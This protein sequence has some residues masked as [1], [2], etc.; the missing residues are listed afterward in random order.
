LKYKRAL[1]AFASIL[2][3]VSL[4]VLTLLTLAQCD[5]LGE[6][7][8]SSVWAYANLQE[9][10]IGGGFTIHSFPPPANSTFWCNTEDLYNFWRYAV[11][12]KY[13]N[14]EEYRLSPLY[15]IC[16]STPITESFLVQISEAQYR[17]GVEIATFIPWTSLDAIAGAEEPNCP[18]HCQYCY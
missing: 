12:I 5:C 14:Q 18:P 13:N 17:I 3:L 11:T 1:M 16:L 2:V 9:R 10:K 4:V 7:L 15:S 6:G 8:Y